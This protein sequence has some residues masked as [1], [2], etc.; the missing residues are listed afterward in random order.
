MRG[1]GDRSNR[2]VM[3]RITGFAVRNSAAHDERD[4]HTAQQE[5]NQPTHPMRARDGRGGSARESGVKPQRTLQRPPSRSLREE[6][7]GTRQPRAERVSSQSEDRGSRTPHPDRIAPSEGLSPQ[8]ALSVPDRQPNWAGW[9]AAVLYLENHRM[10]RSRQRKHSRE[11]VGGT[12]LTRSKGT[13]ST[14]R[15]RGETGRVQ[16]RPLLWQPRSALFSR[17]RR[18]VAV[19]TGISI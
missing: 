12:G 13:A 7:G 8:P 1:P 2:R 16:V 10:S 15:R 5:R 18:I 11:L 6:D 3:V 9:G 19:A 4:Q 17:V 14:P